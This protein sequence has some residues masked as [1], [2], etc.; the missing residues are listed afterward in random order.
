MMTTAGDLP[1]MSACR[2]GVCRVTDVVCERRRIEARSEVVGL[3][4][5]RE[6]ALKQPHARRIVMCLARATM[7]GEKRG[8]ICSGLQ[9]MAHVAAGQEVMQERKRGRAVKGER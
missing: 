3:G 2:L 8:S 6:D 1:V 7:K 9:Q 5:R 4:G